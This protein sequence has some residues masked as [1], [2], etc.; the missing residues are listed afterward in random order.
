MTSTTCSSKPF[1]SFFFLYRWFLRQHLGIS[2]LLVVIG[3][4]ALPLWGMTSKAKM[5]F[6]HVAL[7]Y[8]LVLGASL[9]FILLF[10]CLHS[11]HL[12]QR[13]VSDLMHAL[14]VSRTGLFLASTASTFTLVI[15]PLALNTLLAAFLCPLP[16]G[17]P[18]E[19]LQRTEILLYPPSFFLQAFGISCLLLFACT[20]FS[21]L[22]S[23]CCGTVLNTVVSIV[24]INIAY[25]AL[26]LMSDNLMG[27]L[28]RGYSPMQPLNLTLLT[29]LSPYAALFAP[30]T[31]LLNRDPLP[32][33][34]PWW[35][36]LTAVFLALGILLNRR[37][38]S[39][40]AESSFAFQAPALLIRILVSF[41]GGVILGLILILQYGSTI[42]SLYLGLFLGATVIFFIM[43]AIYSRGFKRIL[44]AIP[45]Y[46]ITLLLLAGFCVTL[47]S[48][49]FGSYHQIPDPQKVAQV[50]ME[51]RYDT[52]IYPKTYYC[53]EKG[54][55]NPT[56]STHYFIDN[57]FPTL[58]QPES[59]QKVT[60]LH[61]LT[62]DNIGFREVVYPYSNGSNHSLKLTYTMK[63]GSVLQRAY[64][65]DHMGEYLLNPLLKL[66]DSED[67]KV[68]ANGIFHTQEGETLYAAGAVNNDNHLSLNGITFDNLD[69]YQPLSPYSALLQE[70][71]RQDILEDSAQKQEAWFQ[72]NGGNFPQFSNASYLVLGFSR[73]NPIN[74]MSMYFPA[75]DYYIVPPYYEHT[76]K[77]LKEHDLFT[78]TEVAT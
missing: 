49:L 11:S 45:C 65:L 23:T 71:L 18:I 4:L 73:E 34:L 40:A 19:Y 38:K 55:Y 39:E 72:S 50:S 27:F 22:L 21:A 58:S 26:I 51:L 54:V 37:R 59:I 35:G 47:S 68:A 14:P 75:T 2:V 30:L 64:N 3:F 44:R 24:T 43:E 31:S 12:H 5:N 57:R 9:L 70:S 56:G 77:V 10:T 62:Q 66:T 67:F 32:G 17:Y 76:W 13:R 69:D 41:T 53:Y 8:Q 6:E 63:D 36:A 25:P 48:G 15:L 52:F 16:Y 42:S 29:G 33:F 74:Q 7:L 28:L 61:R 78:D 46:L 60:E 1:P 20:V